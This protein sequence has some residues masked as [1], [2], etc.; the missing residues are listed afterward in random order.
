[1]TVSF[2]WWLSIVKAP[3]VE[4]KNNNNNNNNV[5]CARYECITN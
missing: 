1:M 2:L 5:T 4:K 3:N